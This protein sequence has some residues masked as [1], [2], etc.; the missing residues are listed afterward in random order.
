MKASAPAAPAVEIRL[1]DLMQ[2]AE[3]LAV[4]EHALN[5]MADAVSGAPARY[6]ALSATLPE[7]P[8]A[9][10]YGLASLT[11]DVARELRDL[12]GDYVRPTR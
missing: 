4:V 10:L 12:D 5:S 7:V 1:N 8:D 9:Y 3:R 6:D 11:A 2:L